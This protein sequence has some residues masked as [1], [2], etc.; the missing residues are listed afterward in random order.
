MGLVKE[1]TEVHLTGGTILH[2]A[3]GGGKGTRGT[4]V[5]GTNAIPA[6]VGGNTTVELNK[7]VANNTRG[8][9]VERI[10]GCND[11]NGTPKGHVTVHVYKTQHKDKQDIETKYPPFK[12]LSDYTTEN[13]TANDLTTLATTVLSDSE[14]STLT[15][16]LTMDAS[17]FM[18]LPPFLTACAALIGFIVANQAALHL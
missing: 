13:Y 1:S 17:F 2:D 3:F 8:C 10:F 11:L 14:I 15:E 12:K 7:D 5:N 4:D 16:I 6:I 18:V 9:S